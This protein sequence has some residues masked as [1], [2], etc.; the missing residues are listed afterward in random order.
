MSLPSVFRTASLRVAAHYQD[1]PTLAEAGGSVTP[2]GHQ[3]EPPSHTF[4][5]AREEISLKGLIRC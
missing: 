3:P 1:T 4:Q 5:D 2:G